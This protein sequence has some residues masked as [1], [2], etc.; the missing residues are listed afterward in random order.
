MYNWAP[1][2][3]RLPS[4]RKTIGYSTHGSTDPAREYEQKMFYDVSFSRSVSTG[5][6]ISGAPS[7]KSYLKG[8]KTPLFRRKKGREYKG[9]VGMNTKDKK[10][11]KAPLPDRFWR[12]W[13]CRSWWRAWWSSS[14]RASR[15][16]NLSD[17]R[18]DFNRWI[19]H[20]PW[21]LSRRNVPLARQ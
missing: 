12:W 4:L 10:K 6:T 2:N 20:I 5:R 11:R 19:W 16:A 9:N 1:I 14:Q 15:C 8:L 7:L 18:V 17:R 21:R 13:S 3:A